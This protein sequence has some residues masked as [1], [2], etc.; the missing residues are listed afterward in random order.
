MR[1]SKYDLVHGDMLAMREFEGKTFSEIGGLFGC[2]AE[3]IRQ[4]CIKEKR[5]QKLQSRKCS[6]CGKTI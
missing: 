4:I 6:H 1:T 5:R 2:G 3:R